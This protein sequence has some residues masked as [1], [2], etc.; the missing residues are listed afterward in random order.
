MSQSILAGALAAAAYA[1]VS[2]AADA[3]PY[4]LG[5]DHSMTFAPHTNAVAEEF[6]R[7]P[8]PAFALF[9]G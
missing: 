2:Q 4:S 7:A 9:A 1:P 3:L 8:E 6:A 5:S